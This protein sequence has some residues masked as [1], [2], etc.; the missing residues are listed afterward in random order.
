MPPYAGSPY[1][2][3]LAQNGLAVWSLVL[4]IAS[5]VLSCGLL[6]GIPAIILGTQARRAVANGQADNGGL[7]TAGIVL[8]WVAVGLS[9][10]A[11]ALAA[12]LFP[13]LLA[14]LGSIPDQQ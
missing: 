8:G 3:V 7:A 9:V 11:V 13:A 1:P 2:P 12:I 6:T 10:V 14:W 4:G 5:F